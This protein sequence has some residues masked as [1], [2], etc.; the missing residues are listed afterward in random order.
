MSQ[1]NAAYKL[2]RLRISDIEPLAQIMAETPLWQRY[3]VDQEKAAL[4]LQSGFAQQASITVAELNQSPV[5]FVWFVEK[6]AFNR[7]GYIMLIAVNGQLRGQGIG[8]ALMDDAETQLF[9][10]SNDIFLLV[11]DFN[12]TAQQFYL[13]RGYQSIGAIPDYV[14][15]GITELLFR[16][17]KADR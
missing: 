1:N 16:K 9:A 17:C 14:I 7:S 5:G 3:G 11:S 6:G 12:H 10:S 13:R 2:R 8:A 4:R 15:P